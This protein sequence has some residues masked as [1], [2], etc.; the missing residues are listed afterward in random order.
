MPEP[1]RIKLGISAIVL[2]HNGCSRVGAIKSAGSDSRNV[3][4]S[5]ARRSTMPAV[6]HD[7][8]ADDYIRLSTA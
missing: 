6:D 4:A 8:R 3:E 7:N 5:R 2:Q 1:V